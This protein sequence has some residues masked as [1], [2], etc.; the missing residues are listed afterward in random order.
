MKKKTGE[1]VEAIR[2]ALACEEFAKVQSLW[3]EHAGQLRQAI[4]DGSATQA[5]LSE[6]RELIGWSRLVVQAFRAHTVDRLDGAR[7]AEAYSGPAPERR[8]GVMA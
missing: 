3:T 2:L 8:P 5:M 4:L 7:L 6:T 1:A